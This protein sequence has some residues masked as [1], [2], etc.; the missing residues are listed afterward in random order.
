[1]T[2]PVSHCPV[3]GLHPPAVPPGAMVV[4]GASD[5][6]GQGLAPHLS[7]TAAEEMQIARARDHLL[8]GGNDTEQVPFHQAHRAGSGS[9][10]SP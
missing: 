8:T 6:M 1:M 9:S 3:V 2:G 10:S 5:S 4:Q 7:V